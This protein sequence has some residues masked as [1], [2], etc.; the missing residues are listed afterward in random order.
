MKIIEAM[1]KVKDL[2][3][4]AKD[5]TEKISKHCADMDYETPVYS[6]QKQQVSEWLQAHRDVIREIGRLKYCIQKTNVLT[7]VTVVIDGHEIT[8]SITEWINRRMTLCA[9]EKQSWAILSSRGLK[10]L[11][12]Q[13][14]QGQIV[15]AKVR[16][17]YDPRQRDKMFEIL[18]AEPSLIDSKLEIINATTDLIED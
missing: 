5:L 7:P 14:S 13:Q 17:Y 15:D 4:K 6:D 8:R 18:S 11:R 16:Y 1:K 10:D 9:L 12:I 3:R 2:D